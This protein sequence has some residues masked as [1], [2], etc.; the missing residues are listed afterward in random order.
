MNFLV[1]VIIVLAA[2]LPLF[3][4][5]TAGAQNCKD[6]PPG[7]ARQQ[8]VAQRN[9]EA[10]EKCKDLPL[11]PAKKQCMQQNIPNAFQGKKDRCGQ[12][13]ETYDR[14]YTKCLAIGG[15]T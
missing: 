6:M 10:F 15:P 2:L 12:L 14:C 3:V 4:W 8:C 11:G 9:P 13:G 5:P 1:R 7:P